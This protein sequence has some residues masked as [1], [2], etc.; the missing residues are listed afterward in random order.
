MEE[1]DPEM[2]AT[3]MVMTEEVP[4]AMEGQIMT[5]GEFSCRTDLSIWEKTVTVMVENA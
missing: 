2:E 4:G 1:W 3:K 5:T